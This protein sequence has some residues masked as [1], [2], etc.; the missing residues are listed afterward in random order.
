MKGIRYLLPLPAVFL[1]IAFLWGCGVIGGPP[2][3]MEI[4]A[5]TDST[6]QITWTTPPEGVPDSF[7]IYFCPITDSAFIIIGHTSANT[8][9]HNPAGLTG[10]YQVS[11][12]FA[13]KEYKSKTVLSTIPK[14]TPAKTLYELDGIGDAG[15]GWNRDTGTA[16]V[17]SVRQIGNI[18]KVDFYITDF[19][20]GSILPYSIASPDMGPADP[21]GTVPPGD[22]RITG[23]TDPL[24]EEN[25]PLPAIATTDTC[26]FKYTQIPAD[27][28]PALIGC[29]LKNE[30]HYALIKVTK[31]NTQN[32][33]VE[34][35]SWFQLLP[36]F[37]LIHH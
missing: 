22:W 7:L 35:E 25:A 5:A 30:R 29:Y 32:A 19:S 16:R 1:I 4:G 33:T 13:G 21:S 3:N 28:L 9:I 6:V 10:R 2:G 11:A 34:L 14:H 17:Y 27:S 26:Y 18:D 8:Y 20:T 15:Y 37:R 31:I 24:S 23:F 12:L 36:D